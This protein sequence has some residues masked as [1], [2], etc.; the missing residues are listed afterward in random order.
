LAK[1]YPARR[2]RRKCFQVQLEKDGSGILERGGCRQGVCEQLAQVLAYVAL[3]MT[4][5]RPGHPFVG[6]AV[7]TSQKAVTPCG[8][9]VKAGMV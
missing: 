8:W 4:S 2:S 7:S 1:E 3:G 9:G 5:H 6:G